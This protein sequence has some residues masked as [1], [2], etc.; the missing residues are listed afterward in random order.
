MR[1][2]CNSPIGISGGQV[3]R[4]LTVDTGVG[5][6]VG[7]GVGETVS[8]PDEE[9]NLDSRYKF[10]DEDVGVGITNLWN[11]LISDGV[12]GIGAAGVGEI[13]GLREDPD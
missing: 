9:L 12:D 4:T 2:K 6:G 13:M 3:F 11:E 8:F 1:P 10:P 7:V 5:V